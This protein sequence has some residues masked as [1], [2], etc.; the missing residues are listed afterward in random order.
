MMNGAQK[1]KKITTWKLK[2][3]TADPISLYA[4]KLTGTAHTSTWKVNKT[5]IWKV[6]FQC[7]SVWCPRLNIIMK[8]NNETEGGSVIE[9]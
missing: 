9:K 4:I 2:M 3:L 8:N 5:C 6:I 7:H 1:E